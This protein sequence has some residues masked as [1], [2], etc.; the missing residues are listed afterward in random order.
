MGTDERLALK[1][2]TYNGDEVNFTFRKINAIYD[3]QQNNYNGKGL[4]LIDKLLVKI[5]GYERNGRNV[6]YPVITM[7]KKN[8]IPLNKLMQG[9]DWR[10]LNSTVFL[11]R[12]VCQLVY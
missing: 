1:C 5:Y 11:Q 4:V 2:F 10:L 12:L 6:H 3:M 9:N 8:G 7:E